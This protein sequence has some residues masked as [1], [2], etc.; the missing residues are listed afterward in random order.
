VSPAATVYNNALYVF[1]KE[2]LTNR[3]Y[4][5]WNRKPPTYSWTLKK[6]S[7][8]LTAYAMS[9]AVYDGKLFL[10]AVAGDQ[11]LMYNVL[12]K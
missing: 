12:K 3:I 2:K 11:T 4:C 6:L 7:G 1:L 5:L 8:S 9:A 10:F